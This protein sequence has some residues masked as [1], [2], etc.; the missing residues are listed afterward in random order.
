LLYHNLAPLAPVP[1]VDGWAIARYK[2]KL[3]SNRLATVSDFF[4]LPD[5]TKLSGEIW[6]KA[7]AGD[8]SSLKHIIKHCEKDVLLL[9]KVYNK[10]RSLTTTHPNVNLVDEKDKA[11]PICGSKKLQKRGFSIARTRTKQ[12]YH[13]KNCGGW[14]SGRTNATGVYIR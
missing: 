3:N 1:H 13:C 2:M 10:I 9:D 12:R 14:S 6:M 11:C 8:K 5:K 4:G 7:S